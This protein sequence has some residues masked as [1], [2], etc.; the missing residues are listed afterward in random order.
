[1]YKTEKYSLPC[2]DAIQFFRSLDRSYHA[3]KFPTH[4]IQY[5]VKKNEVVYK[6]PYAETPMKAAAKIELFIKNS[7][8]MPKCD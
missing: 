5:K 3:D 1:M 4:K 2:E 7:N 6:S 8:Y